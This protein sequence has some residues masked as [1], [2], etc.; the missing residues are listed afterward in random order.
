M[1]QIDWHIQGLNV[2]TCNCSWG[3]P[4]QFMSLPTDG[5]CRAM[6]AFRITRGHFAAL[7]LD[8]LCFGGLFAWPGAIHEGHGEVQPIVDVR[9]NAAQ[10]EALLKIMTGQETEPGA[11]IFSVFAATFDKVHEP[12]FTTIKVD[13][14][15]AARTG[16]II[17]DGIADAQVEPMRNPVTGEA[18]HAHVALPTGFEYSTCEFASSTVRTINAPLH[19]AWQGKHAHVAELDM[20]GKGVVHRRAA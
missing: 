10:R 9:A 17:V 16:H 4:C 18:F 7:A 19:L 15:L 12:L 2:T 1:P 8:G 13:A 6:V 14:D 20:T 3:C 11:T 5:N